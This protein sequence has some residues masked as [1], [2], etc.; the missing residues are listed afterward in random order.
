MATNAQVGVDGP[1]EDSVI[2]DQQDSQI[3]EMESGRDGGGAGGG[4]PRGGAAAVAGGVADHQQAARAEKMEMKSHAAKAQ[5]SQG[6]QG[7]GDEA[8]DLDEDPSRGA[9]GGGGGASRSQPDAGQGGPP[10]IM[11]QISRKEQHG[12]KGGSKPTQDLTQLIINE[13]I[14]F[15]KRA[16]KSKK[17]SQ[18]DL[19]IFD[20]YVDL[21]V[22]EFIRQERHKKEV[23]ALTQVTT[24]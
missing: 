16:G 14:K 13:I 22:L 4:G 9:G 17:H 10:S 19:C 21:H 3:M 2:D 12:G 7:G 20:P 23:P 5:Q 8:S 6:G 24:S 18:K 11:E 15:N 1:D